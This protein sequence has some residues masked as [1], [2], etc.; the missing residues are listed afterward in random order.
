MNNSTSKDDV[1]VPKV[2]RGLRVLQKKGGAGAAGV[3]V[4]TVPVQPTMSAERSQLEQDAARIE[5]WWKGDSRWKHTRRIY[6]GTLRD[7]NNAWHG[8][9][10][11]LRDLAAM[12]VPLPF[13]V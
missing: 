11:L 3:I 10:A 4:P 7:I 1:S 13:R 5:Q 9:A 12:S 2:P 6:S 8:R